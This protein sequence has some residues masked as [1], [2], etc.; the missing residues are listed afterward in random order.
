[1]VAPSGETYA[2]VETMPGGNGDTETTYYDANG[3]VLGYA[4][5][6]SW[7]YDDPSGTTQPVQTPAIMMR[8]GTG[9]VVAGQILW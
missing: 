3:T 5:E 2:K 1:M 6:T 4:M 9:L 8:T 7:S